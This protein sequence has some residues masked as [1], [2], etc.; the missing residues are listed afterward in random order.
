MS[1]SSLSPTVAPDVSAISGTHGEKT[2]GR[3]AISTD[4]ISSRRVRRPTRTTLRTPP[5]ST[6]SRTRQSTKQSR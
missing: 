1:R 4:R 2:S 3:G 5:R 6:T